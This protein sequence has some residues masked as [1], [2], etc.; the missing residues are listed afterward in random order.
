MA[1]RVV[2]EDLCPAFSSIRASSCSA[3]LGPP[4]GMGFANTLSY[5]S[6]QF[7]MADEGEWKR[8]DWEAR[9]YGLRGADLPGG[10]LDDAQMDEVWAMIMAEASDNRESIVP[11]F[12][13]QMAFHAMRT[14][15]KQ[16]A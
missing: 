5:A 1:V 11:K 14:M 7:P 16:G 6:M 8:G 13:R 15:L 4:C 3:F 2:G 10:G 12:S 9:L